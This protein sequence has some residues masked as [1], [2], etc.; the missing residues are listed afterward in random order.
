MNKI[1]DFLKKIWLFLEPPF[2]PFK[3]QKFLFVLAFVAIILN[4]LILRAVLPYKNVMQDPVRY[5]ADDGVYHMRIVENL[6]LGNHF[7]KKIYFDPFTYFPF[8]TYIH[9][10]PLYDY[11]L[12]F[13]IW[14]FSGGKPTE[15]IIHKIAPFYP[16]VLGTL[17][18]I[19]AYFIGKYLFSKREGLI[20]AFLFSIA[21]PFLFRSLLGAT[22]HHQAEVLFSSLAVLFFI[23]TLLNHQNKKK[24]IFYSILSGLALG[25]YFLTWNG[26]LLFL[27]I[28][29]LFIVLNCFLE[30]F[31]DRDFSW[32][33]VLGG[34]SFSLPLLMIAPFFGHPD[35]LN[36]P[37]YNILHL[38]SF[39]VSLLTF[40]LLY[41]L[42]RYFKK[43]KISKKY[44]LIVFIGILLI[45]A[46]FLQIL[47]PE[48]FNNLIAGL[49]VINVGI[50]PQ[51]GATEWRN[52]ARETIGE[53]SPMSFQAAFSAFGPYLYLA[54]LGLIF[55]FLRFKK[56]KRPEDLFILVWSLS[57]FLITGIFTTKI[58][59]SRF[60]YYLALNVALLSAFI[61]GKIIDLIKKIFQLARENTSQS[62]FLKIGG[63]AILF[64]LL[65]FTFSPFPFNLPE[66]FPNNLPAIIIQPYLSSYFGGA[67]REEDWYK[68][69]KWIKEN[70]P[71]P[72]LNFYAL[73][74]EPPLD[75]KT[76]KIQPYSYPE[77]SYGILST[78]DVGHFL[79]YY[80]QRMLNA[81]QFQQ[82]LGKI[83]EKTGIIVPGE[84]SFFIENE[85]ETAIEML[86]IL[87]TK[88]I[89]TDYGSAAAYGAFIGKTKWA[90]GDT[91]GYYLEDEGK[92]FTTRKYDKSMIVRLHFFDG[93]EWQLPDIPESYV[94]YL[95][96]FR[97]VYESET[98]AAPSYFQ[99][100]RCKEN[101]EV[102]L[103]KIFEYVKGAKIIGKAK[104]NEKIEISTK[105]TTNQEREFTYSQTV[106]PKNGR[107]EIIVPYS[108]EGKKGWL[109]KGTKF[110]VFASPYTLK[111]GNR[112]FTINV[113]EEAVLNGLTIEVSG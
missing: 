77:S 50:L 19:V 39:I 1:K 72:G 92:L 100:E 41:L 49:K 34:I 73:Y 111:I 94:S 27:L 36:S 17:A 58:G 78:W 11:L 63:I 106:I 97:L 15:A 81:N 64:N 112:A 14:I 105:I 83:D 65:I 5:A 21:T 95:N 56:E 79:T 53:M 25:L 16:P 3:S 54:L 80:S 59:Q 9:F 88:Y 86:D 18:V 47:T 23:L 44:F 28:F 101:T 10:A 89:I 96:H 62:Y 52:V 29:F 85:E 4:S 103:V 7:P 20:T 87:K 90:L 98:P 26:A 12:A 45:G 76:G 30:F 43:Q 2:K 108:T 42:N 82:G 61:I 110:E 104:D 38:G 6:L 31:L 33:L 24:L 57:F 22:D 99:E 109:E 91:K 70:T 74:K 8:G 68:V 102:R 37:L 13:I 69:A 113:S 71:D 84:T 55:V 46:L 107:F 66:R 32:L 93:R 40:L 48:L 67:G 51:M 60:S 35:L 75:S